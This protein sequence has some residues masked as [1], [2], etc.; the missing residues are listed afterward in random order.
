ML[1]AVVAELERRIYFSAIGEASDSSSNE[2]ETPELSQT[3][4][5]D[6]VRCFSMVH[7]FAQSCLPLG[8]KLLE[9]A[10]VS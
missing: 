4:I 10:L 8:S 9:M 3:L 1:K 5:M 2:D 6:E 7:R